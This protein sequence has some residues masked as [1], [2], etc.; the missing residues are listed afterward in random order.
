MLHTAGISK[1]TDQI[2]IIGIGCSF[3]GGVE[4][5]DSLWQFLCRGGDAVVEVPA[6]RWNVDAVYDPTPGTPGKTVCRRA[7][8]L[9]DVASFDAGFFEISP[10]EAALMDPQQRLL[11]QV[12]WRALEDAGIPAESLAGSR[13]GVY[14]GA[15]HSDYHGIQQF[16]RRQIDVH[17]ATGGALS[18]VAN[19]LSHR[20]DLRGPSLAIDT[21]C[22]SSLVALDTACTALLTGECDA[23]MVGGVNVMLTPD[24]TIT[25]S[26]A[27]ML[28]PDGRCKA[29][30]ARA[31]GY[32][33]GEGAGIV[34]LKLLSRAL[35][36]RDRIHAVIRG[37]AVNQDGRT[38]TITVPSRDA[39]IAMLRQACA[40]A[41]VHPS[42]IGYVE[43]H[44]TGTAVG[45]P[46]E[47]N[48]IGAVFGEGRRAKSVCVIGSIKT[49]IG[50]LEPAAGIAGLIKAALC[51]RQGAIP[52]SLH[53]ERPNPHVDFDGLGIRVQHK[54]GSWPSGYRS[55]IAAIN[56][57]GFGGTNACA[58]VEEPPQPAEAIFDHASADWWPTLVP[59]SAASRTALTTVCT[60]LVEKLEARPRAFPD[61][62]GTLALRRSHLDHRLVVAAK[63]GDEAVSALRAVA[64][65]ETS[66]AVISGRRTSGRRL[67]FVFTGQGAQ[68]GH[69]ARASAARSGVP[70]GCRAL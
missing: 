14:I 70:R 1:S 15:S 45:D 34:I 67:A 4:S 59:V 21:A 55:R 44:G 23:T 47:A 49:N 11:L 36:D 40:R 31:N 66:A 60:Q 13:T 24:V 65:G 8:L 18:I 10:R 28:S 3:P 6:D 25:F 41:N 22:S 62:A 32:V 9:R 26:R 30:D 37:T 12:A 56:S 35:R 19:R 2:A 27:A 57:F 53:F 64:A 29:F 50:H 69:G 39:Q 16:G 52:P 7:G 38:S 58:I 63:S 61:V 43:A 5:P 42:H 46:I 33:R 20:L 17:A 48:A 68:L 51:V 54:L